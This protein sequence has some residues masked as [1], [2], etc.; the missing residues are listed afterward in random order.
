[1]ELSQQQG[2]ADFSVAVNTDGAPIFPM[3]P[4]GWEESSMDV[5]MFQVRHVFPSSDAS[6]SNRDVAVLALHDVGMNSGICFQSLFDYCLATN[7]CD[8]LYRV[9]H[10]FLDVQGCEVG[11][12]T[13][14]GDL[15][16]D[17]L[18][19]NLEQVMK[20]HSFSRIIGLGV[21][22]GAT[23]LLQ[24]AK[25]HPRYL[26]GLTLISPLIF[27]AGLFEKAS[28]YYSTSVMSG[29][30]LSRRTKDSMLYRWFSQQAIEE[31]LEL[32]KRFDEAMDKLNATNMARYWYVEAFRPD[33]S[34]DLKELPYR[35]MLVSGKQST[36][37]WHC[38]D[39][40]ALFNP[41]RVS[42]IDIESA[43]SLVHEERPDEV[44]R[45][46]KLFLQGCGL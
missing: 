1:M 34:L 30:G 8:E 32:L 31:N 12:N 9:P 36:L 38:A 44:A 25:M 42:W 23:I 45:S 37:R 43:G 2:S 5:G 15:S 13:V 22:L 4:D 7:A 26:L 27:P 3:I 33:L 35:I 18:V 11:A 16:V 28:L 46:L 29:F 19:K 10:L 39:A 14:D 40:F 24:F 6:I 17:A 41:E 21:G 20:Q